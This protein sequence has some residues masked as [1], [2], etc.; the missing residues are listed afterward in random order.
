ME[1]MLTGNN[2]FLGTPFFLVTIVVALFW[3]A[4]PALCSILLAALA[5]DY[6]FLPPTG[7]FDA[8][9]WTDIAPLV[10]YMIAAISIALITAQRERARQRALFAEQ[11]AQEYAKELEEINAQLRQANQLKDIFF[12]SASHELKTPLTTIQGQAQIGLRRLAKISAP[13]PQLE[14]VQNSLQKIDE[15]TH[16]LHGLVDDLLDLGMLSAGKMKLRRNRC[17]L[18]D[19]CREIVND[20]RL[21]SGRTIELDLPE[22]DVVLQADRER[23]NQVLQNLVTNAI[24]YSTEGSTVSVRVLLQP[25]TVQIQVHNQGPVIPPEQRESI[26]EPFYRAPNSH[27]ARKEGWGLGLAISRDIIERHNGHIW[28]ESSASSGTTFFVELPLS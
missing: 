5:I 22:P 1:H 6:Y 17:N 21:L 12:S 18:G 16:R 10:P 4:G 15:Q 11:E 23:L 2:S 8:K 13:P 9:N 14:P 25:S 24:K 19:I 28:V 26:F 7:Q 20:Q 3:G 27:T